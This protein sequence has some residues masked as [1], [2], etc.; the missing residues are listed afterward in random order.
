MTSKE[1]LELANS[2]YFSKERHN[3]LSQDYKRK[4]FDIIISLLFPLG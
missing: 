2:C 3:K 1:I 4:K